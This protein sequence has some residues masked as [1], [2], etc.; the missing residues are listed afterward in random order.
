MNRYK[1]SFRS[2]L[3]LAILSGIVVL[4]LSAVYSFKTARFADDFLR[5]LGISQSGAD[6]KITESFLSGSLNVY[7]VKNAKN[8]L[9]NDRKAVA[10]SLLEYAKKHVSSPSFR[11]EYEALRQ[12]NRPRQDSAKTPEQFRAESIALYR[13]MLTEN[14]AH[15]K[16]ADANSK[17]IFEKIV[18]EGKKQLAEA[19]DPNSKQ[20]KHYRER[21]PE[22]AENVAN[23]NKFL[24]EKWES[25]YPSDPLK[26]IKPRLLDFLSETENIDFNAE[27]KDKN[28]KK[29]FVNPEY[30][31]KSSRW[32]MAF[33]A[34]KEVVIPAREFV[35]N[36][37]EEIQ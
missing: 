5:Q 22:Y 7:G 24:L 8:I 26:Y 15:L 35:Q 28:N 3:R 11:K 20:N 14:E 30:E 34:G 29:I 31:R 19:E 21:F 18:E 9:L 6:E 32:K 1:T 2:A 12:K 16:K 37:I 36:W 27:L 13:K 25:K 4:S 33:R 10:T 23:T 17:A